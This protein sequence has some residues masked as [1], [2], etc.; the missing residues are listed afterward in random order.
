[1]PSPLDAFLPRFDARERRAV[2]VRAP[3]AL[4]FDVARRFDMQ[5]IFLVRVIFRLREIVMGA[6]PVERVPRAFLDEMRALGWGCLV[7][8]P[9][10]IFVGGARCQPWNANV[11]FTPIA[12][13]RF[14]TYAEPDQ[15]KIAWTVE[16]HARGTERTELVSETRALAT[17]AGAR[18]RFLRYWRW[19]RFG[20]FTIRWLLLP[21][22]RRE[23]EAVYRGRRS[24]VPSI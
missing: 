9:G 24:P 19:A 13:D 22:I 11:V 20:I 15:V 18:L 5:S 23:A 7:E 1:M 12:P 2:T 21:A 4:V 17:D 3:A 8:R 6:A 10:E 14:A 16:C